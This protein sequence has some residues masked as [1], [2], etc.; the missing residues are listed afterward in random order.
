M[1]FF[2]C[3]IHEF[4]YNSDGVFSQ[5]QMSV[6]YDLPAEE[7]LERNTKIY[8]LIAPPGIHDIEFDHE[9]SKNGYIE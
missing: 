1:L 8:V 9:M 7:D 4:T 5:S 6:L 2:Q 3:A